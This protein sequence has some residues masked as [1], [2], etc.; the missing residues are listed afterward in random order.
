MRKKSKGSNKFYI[1]L[2]AI[3]LIIFVA[4]GL[5]L[6][7]IYLEQRRE[8]NFY[9]ELAQ[10]VIQD[11]IIDDFEETVNNDKVT[12]S[13]S[14]DKFS[15]YEMLHRKN[16]DMIG[17]ISIPDTRVNY[18]VMQ[19]PDRPNYYLRRS[20][21]GKYAAMGCPYV[22]E[23]CVINKP[24]DNLIIYGHNLKSRVMFGD[25]MKYKDKKFWEKHK[26]F[27]FDT[28]TQEQT[29]EIISVFKTV[30]S[31]DEVN[32]D[33]FKFYQFVDAQ[34]EQE[35]DNYISKVKE[36]SLYDTGVS[37]QYG[38]KLVTL[39]TCEYSKANGRLIVVAKK[40]SS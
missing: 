25:L 37:A 20:F 29:Y 34:N 36:L 21:D 12:D 40:I 15:K 19:T 16:N 31:D 30:V 27:N 10:S 22:Q 35:F 6:A 13:D 14:Y 17:W 4:S 23:N 3:L 28:I 33:E 8:Q 9:D 24:S 26:T 18:P 38:D 11:D 32:S 39:A 5:Y 7:N 1:I 2:F